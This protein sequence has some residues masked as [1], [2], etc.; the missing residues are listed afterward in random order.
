MQYEGFG[1]DAEPLVVCAAERGD[2]VSAGPGP[3]ARRSSRL[4]TTLGH[5]LLGQL[6]LAR[7]AMPSVVRAD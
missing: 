2:A 5:V 3:S 1:G 6:E 7:R 4:R